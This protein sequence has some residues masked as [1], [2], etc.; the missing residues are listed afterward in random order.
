MP[1][2][3]RGGAST[4]SSNDCTHC[5]PA[6]VHSSRRALALERMLQQRGWPTSLGINPSRLHM[7]LSPLPAYAY[8]AFIAD[9]RDA[10]AD[11]RSGRVL[12]AMTTVAYGDAVEAFAGG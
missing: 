1:S 12:K 11:V 4:R 2:R 3:T 6:C 10:V 8:E 9:A 7:L 5:S